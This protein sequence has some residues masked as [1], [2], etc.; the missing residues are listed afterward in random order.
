MKLTVAVRLLSLTYETIHYWCLKVGQ[1]R[2][3]E[4]AIEI[5]TGAFLGDESTI[6]RVALP[7]RC[8][9]FQQIEVVE[10]PLSKHCGTS[11]N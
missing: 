7:W 6:A 1:T 5:G 3:R 10:S 11:L 9:A 8:L 2:A 4:E